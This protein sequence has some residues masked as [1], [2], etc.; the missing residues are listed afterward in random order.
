MRIVP[1]APVRAKPRPAP[2]GGGQASPTPI[3][4]AALMLALCFLGFQIANALRAPL[5]SDCSPIGDS[6]QDN[7]P[8]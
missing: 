4:C 7:C 5:F 1:I 8:R 2:A 3:V 6:V